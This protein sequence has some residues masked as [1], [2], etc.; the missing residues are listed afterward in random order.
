MIAVPPP[1]HS[2]GRSPSASSSRLAGAVVPGRSE[3]VI[4]ALVPAPLPRRPPMPA[5][6]ADLA[7]PPLAVGTEP[8]TVV[9]ATSR[10]DASGRVAAASVATALG[11]PPG[12]RLDVDVVRATVVVRQAATGRRAVTARGEIPLP[13]AARRMCR[14]DTVRSYCSR[15]S[16]R[17]G[18]C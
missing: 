8:A 6:V 5:E 3:Q 13:A 18:C 17:R 16:R 4:D 11:W 7:P 1:N 2:P 14:I 9:F 10:V 12:T 15:R